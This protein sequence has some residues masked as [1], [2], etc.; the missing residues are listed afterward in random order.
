MSEH[1]H[2]SGWVQCQNK[3]FSLTACRQISL[4]M[5]EF[6]DRTRAVIAVMPAGQLE[7]TFAVRR[8]F[9][10]FSCFK[11]AMADHAVGSVLANRL[12]W[13]CSA[14]RA[15]NA[16]QAGGSVPVSWLL[17]SSSDCSVGTKRRVEGAVPVRLEKLRSRPT[18]EP[19][20]QVTRVQALTQGSPLTHVDRL[21]GLPSSALT[22]SRAL[23]LL[24]GGG[25]EGGG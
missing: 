12:L 20:A 14:V 5:S 17:C 3:T 1:E 6:P 7:G 4:T 13:A 22:A 19:E 16:L 8:L 23:R 25:G 15:V 9:A 21:A 10:R 24:G 11:L 18:T 2:A